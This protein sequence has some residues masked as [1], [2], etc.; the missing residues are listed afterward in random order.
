MPGLEGLPRTSDQWLALTGRTALF[1]RGPAIRSYRASAG[2]L[3][4]SA[5]WRVTTR[6]WMTFA[7][8]LISFFLGSKNNQS[9]E[10]EGLGKY[11]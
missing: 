7:L 11:D 8:I 10:D 9:L 4:T 6:P 3:A 2:E 5:I 1:D